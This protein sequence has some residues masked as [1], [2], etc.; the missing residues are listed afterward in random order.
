MQTGA[1]KPTITVVSAGV[2]YEMPFYNWVS[3]SPG[4]VETMVFSKR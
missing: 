2:T 1:S 4:E 3:S